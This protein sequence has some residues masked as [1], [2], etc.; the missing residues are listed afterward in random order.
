[1]E[2]FKFDC[3]VLNQEPCVNENWKEDLN[4]MGEMRIAGERVDKRTGS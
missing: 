1:M 3:S 4:W 2:G